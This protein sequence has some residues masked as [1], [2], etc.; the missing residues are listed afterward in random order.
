MPA[1]R[2]VTL[3]K[4]SAIYGSA[5]V[6]RVSTETVGTNVSIQLTH[7]RNLRRDQVVVRI[8]RKQIVRACKNMIYRALVGSKRFALSMG[9]YY[10]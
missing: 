6:Q 3:D 9:D 8:D 2:K 10:L 5:W 1:G 4:H 7:R